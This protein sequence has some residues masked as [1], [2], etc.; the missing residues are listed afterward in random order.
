MSD[1]DSDPD[2]PS[3]KP[4]KLGLDEFE[5][6]NNIFAYQRRSGRDSSNASDDDHVIGGHRDDEEEGRGKDIG[7]GVGAMK[8]S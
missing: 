1:I 4:N 6:N 8:L 5:T 3:P 7:E 2:N